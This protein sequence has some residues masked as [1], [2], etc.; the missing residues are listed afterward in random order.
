[1]AT[2][3]MTSC[4]LNLILSPPL[5]HYN[6]IS[7]GVCQYASVRVSISVR[8]FMH[9]CIRVIETQEGLAVVKRD[10]KFWTVTLSDSLVWSW[11]PALPTMPVFYSPVPE[12]QMG[13]AYMGSSVFTNNRTANSDFTRE[14]EDTSGWL[15]L[16]HCNYTTSVVY[17][18]IM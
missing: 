11:S 12:M 9:G 13:L 6:L 5:L 1:M 4:C 10:I 17:C 3:L 18:S 8:A 7:S 2:D 16:A 14:Q 15:L